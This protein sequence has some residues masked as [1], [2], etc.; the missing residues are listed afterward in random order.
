[1]D[2]R[3]G[4]EWAGG[5]QPGWLTVV[6]NPRDKEVQVGRT[7]ADSGCAG[8]GRTKREKEGSMDGGETGE[9]E[10]CE[11]VGGRDAPRTTRQKKRGLFGIFAY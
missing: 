3:G 2:C 5:A 1:M 7:D 4:L 6:G 8:D 10:E 11:G 9:A